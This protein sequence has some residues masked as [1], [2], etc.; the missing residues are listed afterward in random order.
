MVFSSICR[1]LFC[2]EPH[3]KI[4][5]GWHGYAVDLSSIERS[6]CTHQ[7]S[8]LDSA[9]SSVRT[10]M[11][12]FSWLFMGG[13]MKT[14]ILHSWKQVVLHL[15]GCFCCGR[16]CLGGASALCC[17][18]AVCWCARSPAGEF[19]VWRSVCVHEC[20]AGDMKTWLVLAPIKFRYHVRVVRKGQKEP[21]EKAENNKRRK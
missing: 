9:M 10:F 12:A 17:G 13:T 1:H 2:P 8:S 16:V 6:F 7:M 19:T 3:W 18:F 15:R 14:F 5:S 4:W 20:S 21:S 11:I